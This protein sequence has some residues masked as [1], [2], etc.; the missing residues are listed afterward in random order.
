MVAALKDALRTLKKGPASNRKRWRETVE[1]FASRERARTFSFEHIC[2]QLE[3]SP[4]NL[5]KSLANI[6]GR[7]IVVLPHL[8]IV[9]DGGRVKPAKKPSTFS[10]NTVPLPIYGEDVH[11]DPPPPLK[12]HAVAS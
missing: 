4:T 12:L 10:V 3:L 6:T 1:W 2:E 8:R 7:T 5:R 11:Q 9:R